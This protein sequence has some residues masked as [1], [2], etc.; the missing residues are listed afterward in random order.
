M[1]SNV[2]AHHQHLSN[3]G[4]ESPVEHIRL[5]KPS[6][7][8]LARN[9]WPAV[10][11]LGII[12]LESTDVASSANTS[13]LLYAV[14]SLLIPRINA[15][16]RRKKST[17]SC[18]RPDTSWAMESWAP[19]S[20]RAEKHQ[21]RPDC[22][23]VTATLGDVPARPLA[24]GVGDD[25][26]AGRRDHRFSRRDSSDVSCRREPGDGRM[27]CSIPAELPCSRSSFTMFSLKALNRRRERIAQPEFSSTR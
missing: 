4:A 6:C 23:A 14:L 15:T 13:G 25:R 12:R 20:S 24:I 1:S 5:L 27:S 21:P 8:N 7:H 2:S 26:H 3:T 16:S 17:R 9:W 22:A 11:W 10:V 18:A 19:W